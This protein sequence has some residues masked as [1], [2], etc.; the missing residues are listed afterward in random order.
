[1]RQNCNAKI[2]MICAYT[3]PSTM[4]L[5]TL[6]LTGL[7]RETTL[8]L[9]LRYLLRMFLGFLGLL[10]LSKAQLSIPLSLSSQN[11][12]FVLCEAFFEPGRE[13]ERPT[14]LLR[15]CVC[16]FFF[17]SFEFLFFIVP[18]FWSVSSCLA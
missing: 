3:L 7:Q 18:I 14:F 9:E 1:M 16:V 2:V 11:P 6:V 8:S 12:R 15:V 4:N 17:L 10:S 13:K 5:G